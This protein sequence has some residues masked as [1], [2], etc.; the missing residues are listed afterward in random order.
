VSFFSAHYQ[1][2]LKQFIKLKL[3]EQKVYPPLDN[4]QAPNYLPQ[5]EGNQSRSSSPYPMAS[6]MAPPSYESQQVSSGYPQ[7]Q[8]FQ[9]QPGSPYPMAPPS[10]G[11][12]PPAMAMQPVMAQPPAVA[13]PLIMAQ[14]K[15]CS[16]SIE[17]CSIFQ[18]LL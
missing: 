5:M 11:N 2:S 7:A 9:P 12:Q 16:G 4:K 1:I 8:G 18:R 3:D 14:L 13:Q 17:T 10:D 15:K 6:P